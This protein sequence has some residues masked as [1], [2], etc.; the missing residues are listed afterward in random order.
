MSA[1][2]LRLSPLVSTSAVLRRPPPWSVDPGS[3]GG[4]MPLTRNFSPP[5]CYPVWLAEL[6]WPVWPERRHRDC[7]PFAFSRTDSLSCRQPIR[8]GRLTSFRQNRP[9]LGAPSELPLAVACNANRRPA[10]PTTA[11]PIPE[12]ATATPGRTGSRRGAITPR[13]HPSRFAPPVEVAGHLD[14]VRPA[15]M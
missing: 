6:C 4:L 8:L 7:E 1:G 11:E 12:P 10:L 5:I 15:G 9:H 3:Q 2:L 14:D 13:F